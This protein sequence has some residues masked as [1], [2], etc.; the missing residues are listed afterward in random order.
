MSKVLRRLTFLAAAA[1]AVG[2]W[3]SD[4]D[5]ARDALR[6]GL[7]STAIKYAE[8]SAGEDPATQTQA[9]YVILTQTSTASTT[10]S[11]GRWNNGRSSRSPIRS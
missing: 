10:G 6:D 7:W 8:K 5:V 4:L 3:A 2:A 1:M 9:R 11:R